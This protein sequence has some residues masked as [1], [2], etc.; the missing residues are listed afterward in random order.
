MYF[1]DGHFFQALEGDRKAVNQTYQRITADPRHAEVTILSLKTIPERLFAD[2]SMKY[3]PAE[4]AVRQF[5]QARN[6]QR[7]EP[8]RFH[9][10]EADALIDLFQQ[11]GDV[12]GGV[13]KKQTGW[14]WWRKVFG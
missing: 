2:W 8:L 4:E 14:H 7:F 5:I 9:E 6:F 10:E 1:G 13:R 3:V 12:G 11:H